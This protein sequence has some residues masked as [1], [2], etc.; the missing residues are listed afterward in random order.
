MTNLNE[1]E[2]VAKLGQYAKEEYKTIDDRFTTI[3]EKLYEAWKQAQTPEQRETIWYQAD[4]IRALRASYK[5]DIA[6]GEVAEHDMK[7]AKQ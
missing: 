2:H 4:A 1:L 3:E 5:H 6:L 7:N